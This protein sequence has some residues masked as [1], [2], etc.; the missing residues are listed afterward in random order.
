MFLDRQS[1]KYKGKSL[2]EKAIIKPPIKHERIFHDQ[3]C[4]LYLKNSEGKLNSSQEKINISPKEAVLFQCDTYFMEIISSNNEDVVEVIAFH[5]YPEILKKLFAN[6]LPKSIISGAKNVNSQII[7]NSEIISKFI[8]SLEF[9]FQNPTL[10]NDDLLELKIKELVLLLIQSK[11]VESIL[12]L[13]KNLYSTRTDD[14][15]K[16][17]NLH[18][19]SNLSVD[20]LAKLCSMSLSTF[21][22][23][24]KKA[25]GESPAKHITLKRLQKSEKLLRTT[26]M[27]I[28]EVAFKLGYNDPQYFTRVFKKSTGISPT[29]FRAQFRKS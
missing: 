9:Y 1:F 24:F 22:R 27:R 26:A 23:E 15:R 13:I 10:V 12:Q 18:L 25:F 4:F 17:V 29:E 28:N 21:K 3:G 14:L 19:Y 5:L 2:I 8:E 20:D 7:V 16:T 11:N 6:E